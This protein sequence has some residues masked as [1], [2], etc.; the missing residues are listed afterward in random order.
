MNLD[1]DYGD[2]SHNQIYD[3]TMAQTSDN[4]MLD[5]L[6]NPELYANT[7]TYSGLG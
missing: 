2:S 1:R 6:Q 3:S 7:S 4:T 5:E